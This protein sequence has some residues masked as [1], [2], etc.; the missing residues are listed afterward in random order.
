M[1]D[2][3]GRM[4]RETG[5]GDWE[6]LTGEL[7]RYEYVIG[8]TGQ[9]SYSAPSGYHDDCVMAL[10]LAEWGRVRFG[11]GPGSMMRIPLGSDNAGGRA[12]DGRDAGNGYVIGGGRRPHLAG[13]RVRVYG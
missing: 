5:C 4:S 3:G 9:L 6:V 13:R 7:Q 2:E 1:K 10:A 12:S 8:P 11:H